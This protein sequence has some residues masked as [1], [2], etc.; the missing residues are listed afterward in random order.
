LHPQDQFVQ[1][2]L[3]NVR[4]LAARAGRHVKGMVRMFKQLERSE[5]PDSFAERFEKLEVRKIISRSLQEQHRNLHIEKM[6]CAFVGGL[7]RRMKRNSQTHD[8]ALNKSIRNR[9]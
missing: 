1:Q 9:R 4:I 7:G 8:A 2:F 3:S 6:L 5:R